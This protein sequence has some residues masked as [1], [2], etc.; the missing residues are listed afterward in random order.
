[1]TPAAEIKAIRAQ[2]GWSQQALGEALGLTH[3]LARQTVSRW[4]RGTRTPSKTVLRLARS[5][6][7]EG[8][9]TATRS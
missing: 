3:K 1:M 7:Y 9:P 8:P 4:E 5:F 2:L 6:A